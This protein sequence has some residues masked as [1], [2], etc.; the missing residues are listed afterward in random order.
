VIQKWKN[1]SANRPTANSK[2]LKTD[3][4]AFLHALLSTTLSSLEKICEDEREALKRRSGTARL[5]FL[6]SGFRDRMAAGTTFDAHG[7]YRTKFYDVVFAKATEVMLSV[8]PRNQFLMSHS[9]CGGQH[10][11]FHP[12]PKKHCRQSTHFSSTQI[13][14]DKLKKKGWRRTGG[15]A[16]YKSRCIILVFLI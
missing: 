9:E 3:V 7:D 1:G 13:F 4:T 15:V 10:L 2:P 8:F 11:T 5:T 12:N 6:S 16:C 14:E